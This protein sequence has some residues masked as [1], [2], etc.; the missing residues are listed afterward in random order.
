MEKKGSYK[1]RQISRWSWSYG[2]ILF[3][4]ILLFFFFI[5]LAAN[6]LNEEIEYYNEM[7]ANYVRS[8]FDN[9]ISLITAT[10]EDLLLDSSLQVLYSQDESPSPYDLYLCMTAISKIRN[11]KTGLESIFIYSPERDLFVSSERYGSIDDI[12]RLQESDIRLPR[13]KI[14]EI[15]NKEFNTTIIEDASYFLQSGREINRVLIARP[16]TFVSTGVK[17]RFYLAAVVDTSSL[18]PEGEKLSSYREMMIFSSI[19]GDLIYDFSGRGE[20]QN[21]GAFEASNAFDKGIVVLSPSPATNFTYVI[22]MARSEYFSALY[23]LIFLAI[24]YVLVAIVFG[25]FGVRLRVRREWKEMEEEMEKSNI[26]IE[27]LEREGGRYT[28]FVSSVSDLRKEKES[29]SDIVKS[30]AS[31][32]KSVML[33]SLILT[34]EDSA[35]I[36]K[37]SLKACGIE[38]L[39]TYF[40]V[41]IAQTDEIE[42]AEEAVS[43]RLLGENIQVLPFST[44]QGASFLLNLSEEYARDDSRFYSEIAREAKAMIKDET[45]PISDAAAS[46]IV[47]DLGKVGSA[48]LECINAIEWKKSNSMDEFIFYRDVVEMTKH[49][50]FSYPAEKDLALGELIYSG[51]GEEA[52]SLIRALVKENQ[53]SGLSPRYLRYLLFSISNTVLKTYNRASERFGPLI[54]QF[55]IPEVLQSSNFNYSLS[56]V[57]LSVMELSNAIRDAMSDLGDDSRESYIIYKKALRIIS[58]RYSDVSL[59][60]SEI[61]DRLGVSMAYLS[62]VFKKYHNKNISDYISSYRVTEAKRLLLDG[63]PIGEIVELCGF[64]SLRTFMRLFKKHEGVTTGQY[65]DMNREE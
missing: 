21:L 58:D 17:N 47:D 32:L 33:D 38:L 30:Q 24:I 2:M 7:A 29:L 19:S 37:E 43:A 8:S 59:N 54:P 18:F 52:L 27:K 62:K 36:S 45:F 46:D 28:P 5:L 16:L 41:F 12:Y 40:V 55:R 51:K 26:D 50:K 23:V 60:V 49:I 44:E 42:K 9:T 61:A 11:T 48:Y 63:V 15:F 6:V 14:H 64:G 56:Q 20:F 4:P 34:R 39:S 13:E 65:R 35:L 31:N 22:A 1:R 3:I 57:E 25:I 53:E 10:S